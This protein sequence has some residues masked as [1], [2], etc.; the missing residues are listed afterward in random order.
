MC[1]AEEAFPDA[2]NLDDPTAPGVLE[3]EINEYIED[4]FELTPVT[5]LPTEDFHLCFHV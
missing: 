3:G 1:V 4:T 5:N 2:D